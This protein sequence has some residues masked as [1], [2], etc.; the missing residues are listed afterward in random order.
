MTTA[1]VGNG[2]GKNGVIREGSKRPVL[3]LVK[4]VLR[5]NPNSLP[6]KGSGSHWGTVSF[7][8]LK[9][10]SL[11][12]FGVNDLEILLV[13]FKNST[14]VDLLTTE[15]KPLKPGLSATVL[16]AMSTRLRLLS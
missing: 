13:N 10:G 11:L 2:D 8:D 1:L 14:Q 5:V 16:L 3:P 15:T 4:Y 9:E 6:F 12:E 7:L